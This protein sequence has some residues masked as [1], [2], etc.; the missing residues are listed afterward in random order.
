MI[1]FFEKYAHQ[2]QP[3]PNSGCWFWLGA[4]T[5]A[6]KLAG[7]GYGVV[8]ARPLPLQYTHRIAYETI[9]GLGSAAGRMVLHSCDIPL[10]VNP[11]HLSL[12]D[13]RKNAAEAVARGRTARGMRR[14]S[15]LTDDNVRE[16]RKLATTATQSTIAARFGL[17]Q[18][19]VSLIQS[20]KRWGHIDNRQNHLDTSTEGQLARLEYRNRKAGE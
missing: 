1:D 15:T 19:S 10:C 2:I 20:G 18:S 5:K 14:S 8:N 17:H 4:A 13:H 16:I 11:D 6:R 3:E 7:V 9:H 12:G